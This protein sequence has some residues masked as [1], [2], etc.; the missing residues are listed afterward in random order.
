M[1]GESIREN[2][3]VVAFIAF[4]LR[5]VPFYFIIFSFFSGYHLLWAELHPSETHTLRS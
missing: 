4:G 5:F 2:Y 1:R 3:R